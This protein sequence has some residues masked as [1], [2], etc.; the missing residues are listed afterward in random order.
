MV[1]PPPRMSVIQSSRA[2]L[3]LILS[4]GGISAHSKSFENWGQIHGFTHQRI[5]SKAFLSDTRYKLGLSEDV[6]DFLFK[7]QSFELSGAVLVIPRLTVHGPK[8][9]FKSFDSSL[10]CSLG[11]SL[12]HNKSQIQLEYDF[13][14][15]NKWNSKIF[16][17]ELSRTDSNASKPSTGPQNR[18]SFLVKSFALS[19][20]KLQSSAGDLPNIKDSFQE[21]FPFQISLGF[22]A[23]F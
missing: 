10:T 12:F 3:F 23:V 18:D 17:V 13:S 11:R 8:L 1:I 7:T 21:V 20:S 15:S 6:S 5:V 22:E 4:V 2:F 19:D 16:F 9:D 14:P